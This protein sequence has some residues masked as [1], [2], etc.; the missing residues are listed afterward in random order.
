MSYLIALDTAITLKVS[1]ARETRYPLECR[2]E[3]I[4]MRIATHNCS[5][6]VGLKPFSNSR[7]KYRI[8]HVDLLLW[9]SS[10]GDQLRL[11]SRSIGILDKSDSLCSHRL[12]IFRQ[13]HTGIFSSSAYFTCYMLYLK[14][15]H[16]SSFMP[17]QLLPLLSSVS[18]RQNRFLP[19]F[20]EVPLSS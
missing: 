14:Q 1:A 20:P 10:L 4:P 6:S 9:S 3:L 13:Q 15:F 18:S 7:G 16:M 12:N 8:A 2:T 19:M 11:W 5:S 17:L